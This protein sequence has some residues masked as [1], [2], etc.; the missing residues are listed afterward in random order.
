MARR[1]MF[2]AE[3][4]DSD[5]FT[6]LPVTAQMLYICLAVH[7][8]D[9]GFLSSSKRLSE[10]YGG[11]EQLKLLEQADLII[12]FDSGVLV[13]VDW[14]LNNTIRK[15]RSVETNHKK[16]RSCL[17][18]VDGRYFRNDNQVTTICQPNDNHLATQNR[19][20]YNRL[21]DN[22]K[23]Y[24]IVDQNRSEHPGGENADPV[25]DGQNGKEASMIHRQIPSC[26]DIDV[27]CDEMGLDM[28]VT[29][30]WSHFYIN[31]WCDQ[32]GN[33]IR[34]WKALARSWAKQ[35]TLSNSKCPEA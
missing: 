3:L 21:E 7:A 25:V 11:V 19:T 2:T 13:I 9:E 28:D 23:E 35:N 20:E 4:I 24:I 32:D 8:D 27:Y 17:T 33:P 22:R 30:F 29:T 15:D 31:D 1:R 34:D 10:P 5:R 6:S 26:A 12:R 14:Y 16:E 18:L